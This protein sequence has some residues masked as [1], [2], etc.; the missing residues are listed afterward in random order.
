MHIVVETCSHKCAGKTGCIEKLERIT[1]TIGH[2]HLCY[3]KNTC[4]NENSTDVIPVQQKPLSIAYGQEVYLNILEFSTVNLTLKQSSSYEHFRACDDPQ[5]RKVNYTFVNSTVVQ[6]PAASL[7]AG[8]HYFVFESDSVF[9]DCRFGS[10]LQL[11]VYNHQCDLKDN[12]TTTCSANGQCLLNKTRNS[13]QCLCCDSFY[14]NLCQEYNGCDAELEPCYNNGTCMD[15]VNGTSPGFTCLCKIQLTGKYCESCKNGY[16][17]PDCITDLNE[18]NTTQTI[19]NYGNCVNTD[20]S[21]Y[22]VCPL[23]VTGKFCDVDLYDNCALSPCNV[24]NQTCIDRY[25]G[26]SCQ[27]TTN[28]TGVNCETRLDE[29]PLGNLCSLEGTKAC[30]D[31]GG[32]SYI[33]NCVIGYTGIYIYNLIIFQTRSISCLQVCLSFVF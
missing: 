28:F 5:S 30:V 2:S 22:C 10:R 7:V 12:S 14:G 19:C 16:Q 32:G 3:R 18:C 21:F 1:S 9:I 24:S 6:L 29:C 20:G 17:P 33:C 27:C 13:Y 4:F 11:T 15:T 23:N 26:F 8:I 25:N 31:G